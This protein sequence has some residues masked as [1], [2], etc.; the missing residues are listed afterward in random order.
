MFERRA[1]DPAGPTP[2]PRPRP[3]A[4]AAPDMSEAEAA[5]RKQAK[6]AMAWVTL[7]DLMPSDDMLA[8]VVFR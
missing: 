3:P 6:G 2:A 7:P 4:G 1:R 5:L 8:I